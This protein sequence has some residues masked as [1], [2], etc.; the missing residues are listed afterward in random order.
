MQCVRF[1]RGMTVVPGP[2]LGQDLTEAEYNLGF[3]W[4]IVVSGQVG[5]SDSNSA[6]SRN[7]IMYTFIS[8]ETVAGAV[9]IVCY[10]ST[11]VA[12]VIGYLLN[13]RF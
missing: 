10:F 3:L 6:I 9:E 2:S 5:P 12:V 4:R 7:T 13:M 11:I 8:Q 1:V